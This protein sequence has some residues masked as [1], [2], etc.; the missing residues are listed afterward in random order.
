VEKPVVTNSHLFRALCEASRTFKDEH[1]DERKRTMNIGAVKRH[2]REEKRPIL[3]ALRFICFLSVVAVF[4]RISSSSP[5]SVALI[6]KSTS[7]S[8][9]ENDDDVNNFNGNARNYYDEEAEDEDARFPRNG[10]PS[11][12]RERGN[13]G[14]MTLLRKCSRQRRFRRG[15]REDD[16]EDADDEE[17][18][19]RGQEQER[20]VQKSWIFQTN[21]KRLGYVHMAS[22]HPVATKTRRK[23]DDD[24]DGEKVLLAAWQGAHKVEGT[25]DQSLFVSKSADGGAT[26]T[27]ARVVP[28]RKFGVRWAPTFFSSGSSSSG[29]GGG[30]TTYL[31]YAESEKCW[32]C[33]SGE[34]E[35]IVRKRKNGSEEEDVSVYWDESKEGI[36][37]KAKKAA[38]VG[39]WWRPGGNIKRVSIRINDDEDGDINDD[40]WTFGEEETILSEETIPK[41]IGNP[42]L[43][44]NNVVLLPFWREHPRADA[45]CQP[46][47]APDYASVLHSLDDGLSFHET[48]AKIE[49]AKN[50]MKDGKPDWLIEGSIVGPLRDGRL[51]QFFRTSRG[52]IYVSHSADNG[53]SWDTP[54]ATPLQNPN[55]KVSAVLLPNGVIVVC[56]N[57]H[58]FMKHPRIGVTRGKLALSTSSDDG[59]TWK[60]AVLFIEDSLEPGKHVHY[61]TMVLDGCDL[62]ISYSVSGEGVKLATVKDWA[63]LHEIE[64]I[65]DVD[66]QRIAYYY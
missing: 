34:C 13:D 60:E 14:T 55:S 63:S 48:D 29:S 50:K 31:F 37:S 21:A 53:E 25:D 57:A 64:G 27:K 4:A 56:H 58:A 61:P 9:D 62:R 49:H 65:E 16:E 8:E 17:T 38:S 51:A 6:G 52:A 3:L 35:D 54:H 36:V 28:G 45:K 41:V 10:F 5:S 33:E 19:R 26:W 24:D 30:E 42:P 39:P 11:G 66:E 1:D 18:Q 32:H 59:R 23:D 2:T 43:K 40:P 47:K 22:I 44:L 12:A 7:A 46:R 20:R 15:G